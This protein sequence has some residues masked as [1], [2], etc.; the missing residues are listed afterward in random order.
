MSQSLLSI[1]QAIAAQYVG[2][3]ANGESIG[4]G[5]TAL[6]PNVIPPRTVALLVFPPSA[7]LGIIPSAQRDD[8]YDF[9][10]KI[11][12][13]PVDVPARSTALYAWAEATRDVIYSHTSIGLGGVIFQALPQSMRMELDGETYGDHVYD[14][15][16]YSVR[17]YLNEIITNL[18]V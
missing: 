11:L 3:T 8:V 6:L 15:V 4:I 14:V 7:T 9:P 1:A 13:D 12:R 16:E 17:V 10:V 5:P 18:G 2:I